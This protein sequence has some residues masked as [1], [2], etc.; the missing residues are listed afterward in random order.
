MTNNL[1]LFGDLARIEKRVEAS[2]VLARELGGS[3]LVV[4]LRDDEVG[5][6]VAG[7]GF[8]Q[9]F[10][11]GSEWQRFLRTC[12]ESGEHRGPLSLS[13]RDERLPAVGTSGD[14]DSV[15]VLLGSTGLP[16]DVQWLREVLP[17]LAAALRGE[18]SAE[19]AATQAALAR[20]SAH[21]AFELATALDGTRR[22]LEHALR[23]AEE[24]RAEVESVN[25]QLR[26]QALSLEAQ[27]VELEMQTEKL[28]DA[29]A[30]LDE[31]RAS[32]ESAN[33]MKSQFL[34]TMSHELRT[35]LNAIAGHAELLGMGIHGPLTDA[36]VKSLE[37]ITRSQ[38]HLL[39]LIND[40]LNMARIEA[41]RVEYDLR[42]VRAA[43]VIRDL[44]PM[45]EPQLAS[46]QLV[47]DV[48]IPPDLP[49]ILADPE[50]LQQVLL[51]LLS[52]AVKFTGSGG[53]VSI[54]A[55]ADAVEPG[56][57]CLMVRDT[58]QGIPADRL[59]AIFEPFTQVDSSHSRIGGGTGLGLA[60]ARDLARGMGGELTVSSE[61]GVG[62]EFTLVLQR[63]P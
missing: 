23:M 43:E 25:V 8:Q 53:S 36:Q 10:P 52:N 48:S 31:A 63:A 21:R 54:R 58:G 34:A 46:K 57:I 4:F 19:L 47:Y 18:R 20:D 2:R 16:D 12:A 35:P 22:H 7:P 5:A 59:E 9:T 60:I 33:Q 40:I 26:E 3:C 28:M 17:M 24:S 1:R 41:G 61:E 11:N 14:G 37:R 6:F 50:K 29:N 49:D 15:L 38:R 42:A 45:I 51:N 13:S 44:S 27:A 62:S 39:S 55:R 32:A 30:A 56:R